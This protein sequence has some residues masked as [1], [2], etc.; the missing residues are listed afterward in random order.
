MHADRSMFVATARYTTDAKQFAAHVGM[1]LV[2]GD[3]LLR[4]IGAGIAGGA[5][6]LPVADAPS[7]PRCPAC[8]GEMV[9][10]TARRGPQAGRDFWGCSTFPACRGTVAVS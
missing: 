2:D 3:E 5:L 6:H 10:R 8:G 9:R 4:I 7:S 1:S